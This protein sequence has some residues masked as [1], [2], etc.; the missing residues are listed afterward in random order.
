REVVDAAFDLAEAVAERR[1]VRR[2]V[3]EQRTMSGYLARATGTGDRRVDRRGRAGA[4]VGGPSERGGV[5]AAEAR[6]VVGRRPFLVED[7][8]DA[9]ALRIRV[10][11]RGVR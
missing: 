5:V 2:G 4:H 1:R 9:R 10:L 8:F 6:P 3:A 7:A 11:C